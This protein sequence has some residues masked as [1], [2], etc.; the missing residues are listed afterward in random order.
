MSTIPSPLSVLICDDEPLARQ[1]SRALLQEIQPQIATRV[2]AD[3]ENG[4]QA[5]VRIEELRPDVALL[6]IRMPG[7]DGMEVARH[8]SRFEPPTPSIIFLTAYDE[9]ALR[10]FE[11][12]AIDYLLKPVRINRLL[13]ALLRV[14]R[15]RQE[16]AAPTPMQLS[17]SLTEAAATAQLSRK[18]VS[19][20]ERGK[21]LL[22]P[23]R[24]VLYFRAEMK[25]VTLRTLEREYVI[26]ET[27]NTLEKEFGDLFLRIHRNS[28]VAIAAIA[29][30]EKKRSAESEPDIDSPY[31]VLLRG[32]TETLPVSRRQWAQVKEM[33]RSML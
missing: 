2:V 13:E 8:V 1:R 12:Q 25:Y 28:L 30:V 15:H 19:V 33:V 21:L 3:A 4:K 11:V 10:A 18:H 20:I 5:L 16:N 14:Q 17:A 23:V 26:E 29:G 7:M 27:L 24:E 9:F 22:V 31:R 6:D 32:L